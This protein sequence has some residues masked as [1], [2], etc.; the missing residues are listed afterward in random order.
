MVTA[1]LV[2]PVAEAKLTTPDANFALP[3]DLETILMGRVN[4]VYGKEG[5]VPADVPKNA[6]GYIVQ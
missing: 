3:T 5:K 2:D 1:Y 4:A 6:I